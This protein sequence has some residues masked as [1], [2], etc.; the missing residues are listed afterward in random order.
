MVWR[1][2]SRVGTG[3]AL[4]ALTPGTHVSVSA[5]APPKLDL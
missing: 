5:G 4:P 3:Y 1:S 2:V